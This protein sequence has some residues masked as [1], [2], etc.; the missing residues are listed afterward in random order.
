M[1]QKCTALI[2][3]HTRHLLTCSAAAGL[4]R[5]AV[6]TVGGAVRACRFHP[7]CYTGADHKLRARQYHQSA[8]HSGHCFERRQRAA[9]SPS[10]RYRKYCGK[11]D[12]V[13]SV[14]A[15]VINTVIVGAENCVFNKPG[16]VLC[17]AAFWATAF[18]VAAGELAV[19]RSASVLYYCVERIAPKI[20]ADAA[21]FT[22]D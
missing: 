22:V 21:V 19:T 3:P 14:H 16:G 20:S 1:S 13:L 8:R 6:Q 7:G 11:G 18:S 9:V 4:R 5:G 12:A 17:P 2:T 15:T 10:A